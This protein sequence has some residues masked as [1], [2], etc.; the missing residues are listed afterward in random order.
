MFGGLVG[1]SADQSIEV[2]GVGK[3][4]VG[5]A[6]LGIEELITSTGGDDK[7]V[8]GEQVATLVPLDAVTQVDGHRDGPSIG[9]EQSFSADGEQVG[10]A[11]Q[12]DGHRVEVDPEDVVGEAGGRIAANI[13]KVI[14]GKP[15]TVRLAEQ[16]LAGD[17][18]DPV[19]R[20]I[21]DCL[22]QLRRAL[23]SL[24]RFPRS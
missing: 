8:L 23:T 10:D 15:E 16:T 5:E 3:E 13:E 12:R 9:C 17:L 11:G 7:V 19:R 14:D 4:P 6:E 18:P 20:E 2:S 1:Q 24:E 21:V 22:D